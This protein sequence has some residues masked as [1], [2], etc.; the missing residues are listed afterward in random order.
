MNPNGMFRRAMNEGHVPDEEARNHAFLAHL[1]TVVVGLFTAGMLL[2]ILAPT[3]VLLLH[4]R[5]DP[6]V[7]F[8]INQACWFQVAS[9]VIIG[10]ATVVV[11]ILSF[12]TCGVGAILFL[13]LVLLALV[14]SVFA[15]ITAFR[16]RNGEWAPY[17]F[18]GDQVLDQENP[19][20]TPG[21]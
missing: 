2:P 15:V 7:Y 16:A 20:I 12:V 1:A 8:H 3:L 6:F 14:P 19:V 4:N 11:G 10:G 9:T 17:P 21:V 18:V 13:P 5:R